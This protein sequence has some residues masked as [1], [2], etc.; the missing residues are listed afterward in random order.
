ME[1]ENHAIGL[2]FCLVLS[3]SVQ[4]FLILTFATRIRNEQGE[5]GK[6]MYIRILWS[7]WRPSQKCIYIYI[8]ERH[9]EQ[10]NA[11]S[12]FRYV[13]AMCISS[14]SHQRLKAFI[15]FQQINT[16]WSSKSRIQMHS[17]N[18]QCNALLPQSKMHS[19]S[20]NQ[21][22]FL[23]IRRRGFSTVSS[24]FN[25]DRLSKRLCSSYSEFTQMVFGEAIFSN[26]FLFRS[27]FH[28]KWNANTR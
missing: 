27:S 18:K 4:Y 8:Y 25:D 22:T 20:P 13:H 19:N 2:L 14:F 16:F 5:E 12:N 21:M 24:L 23:V 7:G 26:G 28:F 9:N 6:K 11:N 1:T 10:F 3:F 17:I 15:T